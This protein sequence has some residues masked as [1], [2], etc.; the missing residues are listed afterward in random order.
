LTFHRDIAV[1]TLMVLTVII[2]QDAVVVLGDQG[3]TPLLGEGIIIIELCVCSKPSLS[4][5][6]PCFLSIPYKTATAENLKPA[7][8]L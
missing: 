5:V 8:N 6:K 7:S 3:I 2:P 4:R 1:E